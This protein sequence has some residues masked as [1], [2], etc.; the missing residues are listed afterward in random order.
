MSIKSQNVK[1]F[2]NETGVQKQLF[3]FV[4]SNVS[5]TTSDSNQ[6]GID[7]WNDSD[8]SL[9]I[10]QNSICAVVPNVKWVQSK[11]YNPWSSTTVNSGNFYVYNDQ[12]GYVYLCISDNT[13]NK[14][15]ASKNVSNIR[16]THTSGIQAYDDGY[17]WLPLYKITSSHERF[18][19]AQWI[20]VISFD[21]F[22]GSDQKTQ[23]QK[24]QTFC[25]SNT[26]EIGNCAIYANQALST[27]DDAGTIEYEKG[28]LFTTAENISC[29]DCHYLMYNNNKFISIFYSDG[30][31]IPSTTTIR[32][33]Y[34]EVGALIQ[35]NELSSASPF[36]H[37]YNLNENDGLDEGCIVSA[38][39]N[40]D[41]LSNTRL[42][43][44]R[45]N[46]SITVFSSTGTGAGLRFKTSLVDDSYIIDGIEITSRGS[47]Y[48]D[49]GLSFDQNYLSGISSSSLLDKV[50][51][52]L[53]KIDHI[54]FD[55]ITVL[56]AQHVMIDARIEKQ[57]L[58]N[59]DIALPETVNFFGL[60]ENPIG[61]S[62]S[63]Q[64][65]SGTNQNKKVDSIYRT[66]I[67]VEI[68]VPSVASQLPTTDE[69]YDTTLSD[70]DPIYDLTIGGVTDVTSGATSTCVAEIKRIPYTKSGSLVGSLL[71]GPKDASPKVGSTIDT[72]LET[73][74]FVQYTGN[75]LS[76]TKLSSNLSVSDVDSVIIR[77]N[78]VR[79]M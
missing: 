76:T 74:T 29:S 75:I 16:P 42:T 55:P 10:G 30:E 9:R 22:D 66:T 26:T 61:I 23:L 69:K 1:N 38:F 68:S 60:I 54:G 45:E 43:T 25:N 56:G 31:T 11:A 65:I 47:G 8:F 64:I 15:T 24:T 33:V 39:V 5:N 37:L 49:V 48:K 19:T 46:P 2:I 17:S 71:V 51:A 41:G 72:V 27:D 14:I 4:G 58:L 13:Q 12:N 3:V 50:T 36:Y 77:I 34:D 35:G 79:G 63:T 18:I 53:D 70:E 59:A 73:P 52:N 62:G 6:T 78:M 7:V 20:P 44:T 67:K 21:V 32:D 40:L 28:D 57:S